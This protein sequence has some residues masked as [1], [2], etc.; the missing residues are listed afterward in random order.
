MIAEEGNSVVWWRGRKREKKFM[1]MDCMASG[2]F[3]ES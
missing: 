2:Q 1:G 3:V